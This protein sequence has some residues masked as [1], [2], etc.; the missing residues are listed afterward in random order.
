MELEPEVDMG[1]IKILSGD[2]GVP[3]LDNSKVCIK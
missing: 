2:G 3:R 1:E